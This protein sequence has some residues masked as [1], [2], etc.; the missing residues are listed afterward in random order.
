M[1]RM[2]NMA[3]VMF[4]GLWVFSAQA[5]TNWNA[6]FPVNTA[7]RNT[8]GT[9]GF[10]W[11]T[12]SAW[13]SNGVADG[14]GLSVSLEPRLTV[15]ST[16]TNNATV[17]VGT[18]TA[19]NGNFTV[20]FTGS[21][22]F[23]FDNGTSN[24]F[25]N[26]NRKD[27]RFANLR[28]DI[29][30][31]MQLN[32]TLDLRMGD[33]RQDES[34]DGRIGKTI[35]GTGG[36]ILTLGQNSTANGSVPRLFKLGYNGANTYQ[37]GTTIRHISQITYGQPVLGGLLSLVQLNAVSTGAFGTSNVT[38]NGTGCSYTCGLTGV[39]A[40]RGMWVRLSATDAIANG[41]TLSLIATNRI[42]LELVAGTTQTL[43]SVTM[44]GV[45]VANGTYTGG[46]FE[47]LYGTGTLIVGSGG[48]PE[49]EIVVLG[50]NGTS[51]I[52]SGSTTLSSALGTDFGDVLA[53]GGAPVSHTF[54]ITNTG[55]ATLTLPS[56][57]VTVLGDHS[58]DF[59]VTQPSSLSIAQNAST[60]FS[61]SF[62]PSVVG[63]R[64]GLVSIANND[65][66]ENPY[67]FKIQ[68]TGTEPLPVMCV[69]SS[70]QTMVVT[71]GTTV[72]SE[73][74]GTDLGEILWI[75]TVSA[76]RT[77][78]ITNKGT[79]TLTLTLPVTVSGVDSADF[80]V[81]QPGSSSLAPGETASFTI[82]CDPSALGVRTGL[83]SIVNN[84]A[85]RTPYTF[86]I[87][88]KGIPVQLSFQQGDGGAY[89]ETAFTW[90]EERSPNTN[91]GSNTTVQ[92]EEE[93]RA[94]PN[95]LLFQALI[96]FTNI[97]GK[98]VGQITPESTVASATLTFTVSNASSP[99]IPVTFH[100][101]L[102]PWSESEATWTHLT[103]T[104][105]FG[106]SATNPLH[107]AAALLANPSDPID[108][109]GGEPGVDYIATNVVSK[110]L[111]PAGK[112]DV[113]VTAIVQAWV[114]GTPNYG[115]YMQY[116]S[117]DG[118]VLSSD[119]AA[120]LSDRPRLVVVF[121]PPP[122]KGTVISYR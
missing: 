87:Q 26:L 40:G 43:A 8:T 44:D 47:W 61:I 10:E 13:D 114:N 119:D 89:S 16:V 34:E 86:K 31:D 92:L 106:N 82:A 78:V 21:G 88:A 32:S 107:N 90:I 53:E 49:P 36:L 118:V 35:S 83:V 48:T 85:L 77:F 101:M 29:T 112:V 76:A 115:L 60:T 104:S 120:T 84:D 93:Y 19:R 100:Q 110:T 59:T 33:D 41:A 91:F 65:S 28:G 1:K 69:L 99:I 67:T 81:T 23:I 15:N 42:A 74:L 9:G 73:A 80:T 117:D 103:S 79:A 111:Y 20:K 38:I 30:V 98:A 52:T 94:S 27:T 95:H 4:T 54:T 7:A 108:N 22:K 11:S 56:T 50:S 14:A 71:N 12:V 70:N 72:I 96:G 121:T 105:L 122:P 25:F 109:G 3:M 97:I 39:G 55:L 57:P 102:K 18:L 17:T 58:A 116:L 64:T 113:D 63:V 45:P 46:S 68:G 5:Q 75:G 66:N 2:W 24:S 6:A 62:D 51:E 37:G